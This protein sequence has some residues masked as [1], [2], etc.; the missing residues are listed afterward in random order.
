MGLPTTSKHPLQYLLYRELTDRHDGLKAKTALTD[1][2]NIPYHM[3]FSE[4]LS[5][6]TCCEMIFAT[7]F[8]SLAIFEEELS[9]D[10]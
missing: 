9:D 2:A 7:R 10:V 6:A 1:I 8:L 5:A 4:L 3:I